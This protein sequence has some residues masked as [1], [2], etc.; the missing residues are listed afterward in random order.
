MIPDKSLEKL[1]AYS[2]RNED[3]DMVLDTKIAPP[4]IIKLA[5]KYYWKP[6]EKRKLEDGTKVT[7]I[8]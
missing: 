4:E 6:F 8:F 3:G 1:I 7:K 5:K 2:I